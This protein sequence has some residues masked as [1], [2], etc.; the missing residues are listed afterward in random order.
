MLPALLVVMVNFLITR[1]K[2]QAK[3]L[4]NLITKSGNNAILLPVIAINP[5]QISVTESEQIQ[6]LNQFDIIF[7]ISANAV[8]MSMPLIKRHKQLEY[9]KT[10]EIAVIGPATQTALQEYGITPCIISQ[11]KFNSEGLLKHPKLQ[12]VSNKKILIFRGV[13]GRTLLADTLTTRKAKVFSIASYKRQLPDINVDKVERLLSLNKILA[14]LVMSNESLLNLCN[15]IDKK[16]LLQK[17]LITISERTAKLANTLGFSLSAIIA[18]NP[19]E[20]A[21]FTCLNE[22][23]N[24]ESNGNHH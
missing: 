24:R 1:P 20:E 12:N 4:H 14:I 18:D 2:S 13:G 8:Q 6:N 15:L 5:R 16:Y 7:F 9:L 17:Q 10:K 21:I 23:T 11:S 19:S 3:R 22:L